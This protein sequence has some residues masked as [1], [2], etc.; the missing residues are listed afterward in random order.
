MWLWTLNPSPAYV[1]QGIIMGP[2]TTLH[3]LLGAILGWGILSPLAKRNGW[4]PG[5]VSNWETGAK[6]WI[7]WIS[8]A[9]MLADALVS[10]GWLVL[11]PLIHYGRR[12]LPQL[13]RHASNSEWRQLLHQLVPYPQAEG[14]SAVS[15]TDSTTAGFQPHSSRNSYDETMSV[16]TNN[17]EDEPELDAP[18]QHL[19]TTRGFFFWLLVSI[20]LYFVSI[21]ITF[22]RII[23]FAFSFLALLMALLLSV[24]AS[25]LFPTAMLSH[26][27]NI[28]ESVRSAAQI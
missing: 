2:A 6:G 1:G 3:M 7:V 19:I 8:L 23:S 10:L 13:W 17:E 24:M 9:I 11:E 15:T 12:Y 26:S 22:P 4:A 20:V 27:D 5:P 14:Y 25:T 18:P 28:R 21:H 16:A